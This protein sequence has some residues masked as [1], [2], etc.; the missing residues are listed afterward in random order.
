MPALKSKQW[1]TYRVTNS[2]AYFRQSRGKSLALS[3]KLPEVYF[4]SWTAIPSRPVPSTSS[5]AS[6]TAPTSCDE[7]ATSSHWPPIRIA[8]LRGDQRLLFCTSD[9]LTPCLG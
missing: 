6:L 2:P 7:K 1:T 3:T 4:E 8:G 9:T 5:F